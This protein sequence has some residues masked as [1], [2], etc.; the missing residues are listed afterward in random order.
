MVAKAIAFAIRVF[1]F[2]FLEKEKKKK[3]KE[4]SFLKKVG[5]RVRVSYPTFG[6]AG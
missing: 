5:G 6:F 2:S 3:A 1:L 4:K